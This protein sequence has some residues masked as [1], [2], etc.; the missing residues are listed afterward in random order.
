MPAGTVPENSYTG[1]ITKIAVQ[2]QVKA[3]PTC[4]RPI[5][6]QG[7][8]TWKK[9]RRENGHKRGDLLRCG[10]ETAAQMWIKFKKERR[11]SS[12]L[13]L[14]APGSNPGLHL[15]LPARRILL[16]AQAG[17]GGGGRAA[18]HRRCGLALLLLGAE[19]GHTRHHDEG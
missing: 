1:N 18:G 15:R 6:T 13:L 10:A 3:Q 8:V 19:G 14:G 4:M 9:G 5:P 17:S 7:A 2:R 12:L 11:T 16:G